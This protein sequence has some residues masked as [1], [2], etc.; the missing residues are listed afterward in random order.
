MHFRARQSKATN[1]PSHNEASRSLTRSLPPK[2]PLNHPLLKLQRAIGNQNTQRLLNA[3]PEGSLSVPPIVRD[4]LQSPSLA[5]DPPARSAVEPRFGHDFSQVQVHNN[6]R[7]DESTR[8]VNNATSFPMK[9]FGVEQATPELDNLKQRSN[10]KQA[11]QG[12]LTMKPATKLR[13]S[14]LHNDAMPG[15]EQTS[16]AQTTVPASAGAIRE[17]EEGETVRLPDIVLAPTP[18]IIDAGPG[19]TWIASTLTY[20]HTITR[21]GPEPKS[22]GAT[23]PSDFRIEQIRPAGLSGGKYNVT[24]RF[25]NPITFQVRTLKGPTGQTNIESDSDSDITQANYMTVAKDLTPNMSDLNGR[26]PR[27]EFWAKDLTIRHELV[28]AEEDAVNGKAVV[29]EA[30]N[31]LNSQTA[32]DSNEVLGLVARVP[33]RFA[34]AV[35]K[36]TTEGPAKDAGDSKAYGDGAPLYLAR[37][38]AIKTKGAKG[39]YPLK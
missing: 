31:W 12:S 4:V 27:K 23:D 21:D 33:A 34:A 9:K 26:P 20:R 29:K 5:L 17:P 18:G 3:R 37:A 38:N 19:P 22:F 15:T 14:A 32:V 10:T 13:F 35:Q 8:A 16:P 2:H 1:P 30:Q 24:A 11:S 6:A 39:A 7:A 25:Y 28:H 36:R